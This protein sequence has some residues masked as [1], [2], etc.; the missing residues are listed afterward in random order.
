MNPTDFSIGTSWAINP[1]HLDNLIAGYAE[2]M[3]NSAEAIQ[4]MTVNFDNEGSDPGY[5]L[6]DGVAVIPINGPL[7]KRSGFFSFLFGG[8]SYAEVGDAFKNAIIDP[9]VGAIVF[10]IDSPG[11]TV[12][13]TE[14]LADLIFDSR[15]VKPVIAFANGMMASAAYWLGSAAETIVG[16]K[17][18]EV[19]SIGVLM[20]HE[21]Q[22]KLDENI[23][24]KVTYLTAGKYKA[25]GNPHTPLG[26][27]AKAIFQDE[28][29]QIYSVFVDTVSRNRDVEVETVLSNM[30]DGRIFIG[31]QAKDRGMIDVI[32][33]LDLAIDL[34][35]SSIGNQKIIIGG[36][37]MDLKIEK[38]SDLLD[39][40]P[41]MVKEIIDT[42]VAG[43]ELDTK[44]KEARTA[45]RERLLGLVDTYLGKEKAVAFRAVV[46]SGVSSDQFAAISSLSAGDPDD[47]S[48]VTKKQ[49]L[50]AIKQAGSDNPGTGGD[51]TGD[52]DYMTLVEA[53]M[54]AEKCTKAMAM[55]AVTAKFPEKH[56]AWIRKMNAKKSGT[57]E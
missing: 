16:G 4:A 42:A 32:G 23:G 41:D 38:S 37:K 35:R 28:L 8:S 57:G 3:N 19:G 53:E 40:F 9:D 15:G 27:E 43:V 11:G 44:I 7:S 20:I 13:G 34:A 25:M 39:N 46:D 47:D 21:D 52:Q 51:P 14:A 29:N 45:E 31:Q 12:A 22:S 30:A 36:K 10:D 2:F 54:K 26:A 56:E 5:M 17:T 1:R 50:D 49:M 55:R 48:P 18:A 24:V 6:A 33:T